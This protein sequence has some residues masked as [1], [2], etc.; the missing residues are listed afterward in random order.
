MDRRRLPGEGDFDLG[1]CKARLTKRALDLPVVVEVL[2][3][4]ERAKPIEVFAQRAMDAT[5][6]SWSAR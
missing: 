3:A 5:R 4:E 6:A 2:N 1:G